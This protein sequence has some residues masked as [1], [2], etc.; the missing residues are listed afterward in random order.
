MTMFFMLSG[1][2]LAL[3]QTGKPSSLRRYSIARFS[4]IYPIYLLGGLIT[5]PFI[6]LENLPGFEG[7]G[8][9]VK[10]AILI[11]VLILNIFLLQAWFPPL[12]GVWND[13][14][15]W[16][17]SAEM[18]FYSLFPFIYPRVAGSK[19]RIVF[20]L[21]SSYLV[22]VLI[23]G[24]ATLLP[25]S[26]M[27]IA[28]SV[29]IYRLFEFTSGVSLYLL[30]KIVDSKRISVISR[31]LCLIL[32]PIMFLDLAV[33]GS[34]LQIYIGHDWIV[35][36]AFGSVL[37]YLYSSKSM[38]TRLLSLKFL[39]YLGKVSYSFYSIQAF[40]ILFLIYSKNVEERIFLR[41]MSAVELS[42]YTYLLLTVCSMLSYS[43]IENPLR[44]KTTKFL[45]RKFDA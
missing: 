5:L 1:F 24:F 21:L 44:K 28:Y 9:V 35:M 27:S 10:F 16:S 6:A 11:T 43:F 23:G 29:P 25:N 4:R 38:I 39:V 7:A 30:L 17:I 32:I 31:N 2:V 26:N 8:F 36:P 33:L 34:K 37:I 42:L 18:F 14:G 15:S 41:G 12:F 22:M 3:R 45:S 19:F 40:F 20:V 13:G